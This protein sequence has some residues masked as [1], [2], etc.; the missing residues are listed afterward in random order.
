MTMPESDTKMTPLEYMRRADKEL[1][2]GNG[3][4]AAGLLWKATEVTFI[5]LA[6]SRGLDYSDLIAVAKAL[7]A[8]KSIPQRYYRANLVASGL[9]QDHAE[10]DVLEG[11]QL[12]DAYD[13][14]RKFI[15]ECQ[16]ELE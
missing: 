13:G 12:E 4:E 15:L 14:A 1:A 3:R 10:L 8:D 11:Y 6:Q 7:E 5:K 2:A 9:L 16:G